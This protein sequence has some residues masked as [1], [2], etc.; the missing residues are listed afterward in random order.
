MKG[1]THNHCNLKPYPDARLKVAP[2]L[3]TLVSYYRIPT[4]KISHPMKGTMLKGLGKTRTA[5]DSSYTLIPQPRSPRKAETSLHC[6]H[7]PE[8]PK[9]LPLWNDTPK[10]HSNHGFGG[11]N[12]IIVLCMDPLGDNVFGNPAGTLEEPW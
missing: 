9:I 12:S 5:Q 11:P 4:I 1:E 3:V 10:D 6:L 8:G 2:F 7:D